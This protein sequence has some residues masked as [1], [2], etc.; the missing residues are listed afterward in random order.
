LEALVSRGITIQQAKRLLDSKSETDLK[1]IERILQYY[2][3]LV[4][5]NDPKVSR[6]KVGF[7]YR[8]VES[9]FKFNVPP[10]FDNNAPQTPE[11]ARAARGLRPEHQVR[12]SMPEKS[13]QNGTND[14]QR[15]PDSNR[16]DSNRPDSNLSVYKEF[17]EVQLASGVRRLGAGE[18]DRI[19][20][21]VEK[22]MECLKSALSGDRF[23][24]ALNGCVKEELV[25]VLGL[26]DL[27]AFC[28]SERNKS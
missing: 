10:Q 23:Q 12:K 18:I 19:R 14:P 5:S 4:E 16:P 2:D 8:A 28:E 9:P 7:L 3:H 21:Q 11:G 1:A 20:A 17:I 15:L 24:E 22:K 6:S 27:H 13:P 26:P 25:K